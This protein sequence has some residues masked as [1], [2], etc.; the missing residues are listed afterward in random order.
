MLT[1]SVGLDQ[2][3]V[4]QPLAQESPLVSFSTGHILRQSRRRHISTRLP[5]KTAP[6]PVSESHVVMKTLPQNENA[7]EPY[8]IGGRL[9]NFGTSIG[10]LNEMCRKVA[11]LALR[12]RC[13][14]LRVNGFHARSC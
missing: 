9:E 6:P 3:E 11:A 13:A 8:D 10:S 12:L 4:R 2:E 1:E 5:G 7:S 14:T